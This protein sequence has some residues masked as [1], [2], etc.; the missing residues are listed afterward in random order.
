V[1]L[2]IAL[3]ETKRAA[4]VPCLIYSWPPQHAVVGLS[5][6]LLT[7]GLRFPLPAEH[8][9]P[10]TPPPLPLIRGWQWLFIIEGIPAVIIGCCVWFFMPGSIGTAAFLTPGERAA[11][12]DAVTADSAASPTG[13]RL[14]EILAL[15]RQALSNPYLWLAALA[16][17]MSSIGAQ[18]SG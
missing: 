4:Y 14:P 3:H 15:F 18:V 17:L 1:R 12:E 2:A 11:L 5:T 9:P 7:S 13:M 8:G 10:P 16:N 6:P